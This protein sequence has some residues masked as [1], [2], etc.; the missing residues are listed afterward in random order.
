VPRPHP[1]AA[2]LYA[3]LGRHRDAVL[4]APTGAGKSTLVPLALLEGLE[5]RRILMLEPRRLATRAVA[6]RMAS[7]LGERVGATV[8]YRMRLDTR[9][10]ADTRIEVITEGVLTRMLQEDPA[11][12]GVA[13]LIFDE[14]HERSLSADLGLALAL[15]ARRQLGAAFRLLIMSATL[16]AE[17]VAALLED[18]AVVSVPGRAFDVQIRYLGRGAPILPGGGGVGSI[19]RGAD[20][21]AL[22]RAVAAAIGLALTESPGDVLAF[23]PGVGE[24]RRVEAQLQLGPQAR[25]GARAPDG[26][27]V[28]PLYGQ[29]SAQAQDAV[30]APASPGTRKVVLATNVAETSLTIPGVTAVVDSGLVR[31]SRFDPVSGMSRLEL[32]RVSRAASEQRA[33]RAG[34][35]APGICYRL[36]SE[37]AHE[38]LAA[39]TPPE[40]L[41]ADLAPLALELARWGVADA[42][43]LQ[44][45]DA[46]PAAALEQARELLARLEALDERGRLSARG[47]EMAR[48]PA[49]PRL[50]HMLLAARELGCVPLATQLAALLSEQDLLRGPGNAGGPG[51]ARGERDPDIRSRLE[52][53]QP[54]ARAGATVAAVQ[55]LQRSARAL[56]TALPATAPASAPARTAATRTPDAPRPGASGAIGVAA[57]PGALLALAFPDRIGQRREGAEGRYLLA[58][59][60]GAAFAA[61][62]SLAREPMIVAVELDD[63]EREARIDLAVPLSV[64]AVDALF[65]AQIVREERFGW[66]QAAEAVIAR[67]V[68]RLG[69]IVLDEQL[70]PVADDE[71]AVPAMLE[72][73]RQIGLDALPWDPECRGLQAR[74]QFVRGLVRADL[75]AWP[76]SD[77]ATLLAELP[78]WLGPYLAGIT[79]RTALTRVPLREALLARL[80]GAQRRALETLAPR[81]LT[82]P[83]G[84]NLRVDYLDEQAPCLSVRLQ[85]VFGLDETPRIGGGAV[86]VTLKLLSPAQRPVQITR[87]LGG[88]WRGSY[89]QVRKDLRGRYPK[90]Y[91]PEDPLEAAPTRGTR[92]P[93]ARNVADKGPRRG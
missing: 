50:A 10:C 8:G 45:L 92:R 88:F 86:A 24:I 74:L 51:G 16:E 3:A 13:W 44:W 79:R 23:L 28:L 31:R 67:R 64:A 61:R 17:R 14:Y 35:V 26:V 82:V 77:D 21:N 70:L 33:G 1:L 25:T 93:V 46:P 66:E 91:W 85:E 58:N 4:Q 87:D 73:V 78:Q 2:A 84:S 83:S 42:A 71:R 72:A 7:L 60:R 18:A 27:Q 37:G 63:R 6:A 90:H 57:L 32:M 65:A 20:A 69:A 43:Q 47:R 29:M 38:R 55:Q 56:E 68:R 11:L 12:E 40:I 9:V 48:V 36:W 59:G 5:G 54:G 19:A 15:D 49:H 80:S 22:E 89:A 34:R 41:E 30:L 52:L 75:A 62:V 81:E 76:A 53:L 39:A